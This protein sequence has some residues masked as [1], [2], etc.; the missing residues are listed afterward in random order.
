LSKKKLR[1]GFSGTRKGMTQAQKDSF[2][3]ILGELSVSHDWIEFHHGICIG[4]DED[5]HH[6]VEKLRFDV[7]IIGHPPTN[8]TKM[9]KVVCNTR[10]DGLPY[11]LRNRAI[12]H[13]STQVIICPATNHMI[14]RSGTW[15]T[16]RYAK[17]TEVPWT[18]IWPTG[19][20][21][22]SEDM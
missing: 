8:T 5:A 19:D 3:Y 2:A 18:I 17:A 21:D 15:A 1:L 9:A 4:A 7:A 16:Q 22:D 13:E 10:R 12:V 20:Y 11:L 6:I 14:L